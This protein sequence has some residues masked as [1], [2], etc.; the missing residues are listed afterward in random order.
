[1]K[2]SPHI[3]PVIY[4]KTNSSEVVHDVAHDPT[5][6]AL[7]K[8]LTLGKEPRGAG[9]WPALFLGTLFLVRVKHWRVKLSEWQRRM[10]GGA[11]RLKITSWSPR[12]QPSCSPSSVAP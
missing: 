8:I 12:Y 11:P 10:V 7:L 1:M 9:L 3:K 6:L 5:R 4:P 2:P